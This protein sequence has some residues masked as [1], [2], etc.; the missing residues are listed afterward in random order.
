MSAGD[1]G[2]GSH[3]FLAYKTL[4]GRDAPAPDR[5]NQRASGSTSVII[6]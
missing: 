5:D 3:R 6:A 4:R 1:P 2:E